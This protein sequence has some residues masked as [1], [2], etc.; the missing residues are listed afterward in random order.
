M[1]LDSLSYYAYN[2]VT[3]QVLRKDFDNNDDPHF[4]K[5]EKYDQLFPHL[6]RFLIDYYYE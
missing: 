1:L 3:S 4:Y 6:I 2:Q 5:L